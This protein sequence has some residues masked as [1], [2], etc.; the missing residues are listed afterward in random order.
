M[1]LFSA[2]R[3]HLRA[4][5]EAWQQGA[6]E[7]AVHGSSGTEPRAA[8]SWAGSRKLAPHEPAGLAA[9]SSGGRA[10]TAE[11]VC[12]EERDGAN[13]TTGLVDALAAI[14]DRV[15]FQRRGAH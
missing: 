3:H 7:R 9:A 14:V 15:A 1:P 4:A 11:S 8:R 6:A 5:P 12:L 13:V 10:D 2:R